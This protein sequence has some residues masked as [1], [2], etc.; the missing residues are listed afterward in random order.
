MF[1]RAAVLLARPM[2]TPV[3]TLGRRVTL[4]ARLYSA[5]ATSAGSKGRVMPRQMDRATAPVSHGTPAT[6]AIKNGPVFRGKAFGASQTV[7]GE[8][9]FTTSLTSYE[10]SMTDPS[11]RHVTPVTGVLKMTRSLTLQQGS[12]SRLHAATHWQLWCPIDGTRRVR[13]TQAF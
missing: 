7:S 2:T 11:Y 9:V 13:A 8:A 5:Q 6:L 1:R 4:S 12:N 3:S 10:M